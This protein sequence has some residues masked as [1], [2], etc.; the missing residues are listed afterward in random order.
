MIEGAQE[1]SRVKSPSINQCG[2]H[3]ILGVPLFLCA[4]A[5]GVETPQQLEQL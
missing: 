3:T 1:D 2:I 4:I 5:Q